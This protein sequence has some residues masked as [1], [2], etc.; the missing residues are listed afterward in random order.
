MLRTSL[1][2][3]SLAWSS[4]A[5]AQN[6]TWELA[7]EY[8]ASSLAG[9]GDTYFAML[10][11]ERTAGRVRIIPKFDGA[12]G[13]KSRDQLRAVAENKVAMADS[14][15]GALGDADAI[16]L[17]SSLPFL[18]PKVVDARRL[19]DLARPAYERALAKQGQKLLFASPWPPS[20]IWAKQAM[21][22]VEALRS[23]KIRTYD[24]TSADVMQRAGAQA[25]N[26]SFNEVVGN[27][28]AGEINAVLS[29]G[30]GGAGRSLWKYL[31]HFSE[32]NYAIPLSLV[33]VNVNRWNALDEATRGIVQAA[34]EETMARQ[35]GEM[36]GRV[37]QNYQRM[38]DNHMTSVTGIPRDV[39]TLL[40]QSSAAAIEDWLKK[41]GDAGRILLENFKA[42]A[43]N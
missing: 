5:F 12:S 37:E 7:S 3:F 39:R 4:F 31:D 11:E 26:L 16:F 38:R 30:D 33:T 41:T 40:A 35:W 19:F 42:A 10:V 8:P 29:S 36:E 9:E 17:L 21:T 15:A 32:I 6:V 23:L 24:A 34:A 1:I 2:V 25:R 18:T 27:L 28:E 13:Y 20:G 22:S 43:P 14:F